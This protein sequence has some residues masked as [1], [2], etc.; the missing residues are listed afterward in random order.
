MLVVP[1][2]M[3]TDRPPMKTLIDRAHEIERDARVL[4]V[5]VA[6]GFPYSDVP[7]AGIA[8]VV[9]TDG[10]ESL[11][12]QY[13]EELKQMAWEMREAFRVDMLSPAEAVQRACASDNRPVILVEGSKD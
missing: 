9:T 5:T 13:A 12:Q 10:D 7:E 1:Q 6:G 4:N 2:A 3:V 11:A 8:F